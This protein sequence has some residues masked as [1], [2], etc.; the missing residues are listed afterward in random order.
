MLPG[1]F[2]LFL[3]LNCFSQTLKPDSN[4]R[5][6][7]IDKAIAG[8][9]ANAGDQSRLYNGPEYTSYE[10]IIKGNAYFTE[11]TG[12]S[13][14]TV[15]YDGFVYKDVPM[16]YDL[17]KDCVVVL[18]PNKSARISLLSNRVQSFDLLGHHF[19]YIDADT[20]N[21]KVIKS[22]FY[23]QLY[24]GRSEVLVKRSKSI[25]NSSVLV[26]V[27]ETF[28]VAKKEIFLEKNGIYTGVGSQGSVLDVFKDKKKE[29]KQYVRSSQ[30]KFSDDQ[31]RAI[32]NAASYYDQL[33]K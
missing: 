23:D 17:Y 15:E 14:G 16:M 19:V 28:F 6:N 30:V 20:L 31:E 27:I 4:A 33:T 1:A 10:R 8:F 25:Q 3:A 5:Q 22:G 11:A 29:I 26:T 18:L 9:Y 2:T 7:I 24:K 21:S 13:A 12:F 32:V